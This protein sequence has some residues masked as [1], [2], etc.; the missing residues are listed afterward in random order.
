MQI[1]PFIFKKKQLAADLVPNFET[2]SKPI[3]L[4]VLRPP[5]YVLKTTT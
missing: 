2:A 5:E 4:V 1:E 3:A